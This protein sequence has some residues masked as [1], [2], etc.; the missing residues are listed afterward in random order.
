MLHVTVHV[1]C[2]RE[3]LKRPKDL[4]L[5]QSPNSDARRSSEPWNS[6]VNPC[7]AWRPYMPYYKMYLLS[8]GETGRLFILISDRVIIEEFVRESTI[9][10]QVRYT[11]TYILSVCTSLGGDTLLDQG[12]TSGSRTVW[13]VWKHTDTD[14]H[15]IWI[16]YRP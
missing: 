16:K 12:H 11:F 13:T 14:T 6:S 9:K 2:T 7:E 5:D 15:N 10:P 4:V 8:P 3:T 1:W